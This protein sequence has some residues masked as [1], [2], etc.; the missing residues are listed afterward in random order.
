[1]P[2]ASMTFSSPGPMITTMASASS[3][4]GKASITSMKRMIRLSVAPRL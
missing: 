2:T 4:L 3:M 1:M